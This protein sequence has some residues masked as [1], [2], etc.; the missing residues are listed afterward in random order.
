MTDTSNCICKLTSELDAVDY[1]VA[2]FYLLQA[3]LTWNSQTSQIHMI[4]SEN[5]F[6]APA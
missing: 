6:I 2:V 1:S 4:V 3:Q 5:L